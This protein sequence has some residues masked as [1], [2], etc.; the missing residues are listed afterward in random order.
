MR[1]NNQGYSFLDILIVVGV[2]AIMITL[3]IPY[4]KNFQVNMDLY[5]VKKQIASDLRYAQQLTVTEQTVHGVEFKEGSGHYR[6]LRM[7]G[8]GKPVVKVINLSRDIHVKEVA[9]SEDE[10]VEFD[11]YGGADE[12]CRIVVEDG[13]GETGEVLV[14]P[15]G[16]IS[17]K[18]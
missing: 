1:S 7:E 11:F 13:R 12:A 9:N 15:S 2:M 3:A 8:K 17:I 6:V 4:I 16:Y 5:S 18:Q 14:K 10:V